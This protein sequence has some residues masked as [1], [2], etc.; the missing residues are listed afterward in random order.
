MVSRARARCRRESIP[1]KTDRAVIGDAACRHGLSP[2]PT[3]PTKKDAPGLRSGSIG[4][5]TKAVTVAMAAV[6]R[7]RTK[8][9][10]DALS[11]CLAHLDAAEQ[12]LEQGGELASLARLTLVVDLLRRA[13][14]LPDRLAD[15]ALD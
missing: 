14:H 9:D 8:M 6:D 13:Y 3:A 10:S 5:G 7:E 2:A 12:L 1:W 4:G 11:H 15:P